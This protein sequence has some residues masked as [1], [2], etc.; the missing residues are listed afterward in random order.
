MQ[1]PESRR[2]RW[3][4]HRCIIR[5]RTHANL[6]PCPS[7]EESIL[8]DVWDYVETYALLVYGELD[9][10]FWFVVVMFASR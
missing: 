1:S 2:K 9:E 6:T 4:V 5:N 7:L 10:V 3:D 8:I